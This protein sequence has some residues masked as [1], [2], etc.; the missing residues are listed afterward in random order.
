[1]INEMVVIL[2]KKCFIFLIGDVSYSCSHG[3]YI[4]QLILLHEYV[5]R[6]S[7]GGRQGLQNPRLE[8]IQKYRAS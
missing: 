7:R 8:K 4:T 3:L 6:G 2:K 5:I 1:M